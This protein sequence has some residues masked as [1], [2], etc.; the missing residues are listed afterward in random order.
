MLLRLS[1]LNGISIPQ[2]DSILLTACTFRK[3]RFFRETN[4][5]RDLA[6]QKILEVGSGAAR[7]TEIAPRTGAQ[8]FSVDVSQAVDANWKNNGTHPNLVLSQA[9][10]Y[11]LPFPKGCFDKVF[12]F[13][14]CSTHLDVAR[15]FDS[16][17]EFVKLSGE[18]AVDVYNK[19]Y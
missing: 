18:L 13:G 2:S 10:L 4:W 17:A 14:V 7:S 5:P 9:S 6:G 19:N 8:V 3:E 15:G 16:I 1:A 12:C 11:R